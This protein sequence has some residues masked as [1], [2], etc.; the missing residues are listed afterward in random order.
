MTSIQPVHIQTNYSQSP[1]K[2]APAVPTREPGLPYDA[3]VAKREQVIATAYDLAAE[4]AATTSLVNV[5]T[6][7]AKEAATEKNPQRKAILEARINT[8]NNML[9]ARENKLGQM[10]SVMKTLEQNV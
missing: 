7:M 6:D 4:Y 9:T 8:L 3:S 1:I 10:E 2:Y 5:M